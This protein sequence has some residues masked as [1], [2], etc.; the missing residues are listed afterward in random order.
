MW[1][2]PDVRYPWSGSGSR[3]GE[4][5]VAAVVPSLATSIEVGEGGLAALLLGGAA[6]AGLE[7]AVLERV[8]RRTARGGWRQG[9]RRRRLKDPR[10]GWFRGCSSPSNRHRQEVEKIDRADEGS[11]GETQAHLDATFFIVVH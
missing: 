1:R 8:R 7:E 10:S 5:S 11:W 3:G 2:N 6:Q 4:K 9:G